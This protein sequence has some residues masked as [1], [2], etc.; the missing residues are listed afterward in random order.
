[1]FF[2]KHKM[3]IGFFFNQLGDEVVHKLFRT[4][5]SSK[6]DV[7]LYI[8]GRHGVNKI[9]YSALRKISLLICLLESSYKVR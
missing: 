9:N 8:G 2:K 3:V 6:N 5:V 7:F 4:D 1:M